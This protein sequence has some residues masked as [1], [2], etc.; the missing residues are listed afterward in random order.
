[1]GFLNAREIS[2]LD[3][4]AN[5]VV[6]S[7]CN[8]GTGKVIN[9]EGVMGLQRSLFIS[10]AS[11]VVVSLWSIFDRSTPVFMNKFYNQ[12]ISFEEEEISLLDKLKMAAN[13]YEPDLVD[14]KTLALQQTKIEMIEHPYYSHPVH[15]APFV[16]TGK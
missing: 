7:A 9:G 2:Q 13:W 1:M 14:Y 8:T 6:L 15:W 11:S 3:I 5:L 12:M 4:E 16:I 10:G